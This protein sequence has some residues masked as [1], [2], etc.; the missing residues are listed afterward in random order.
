M[1]PRY[2]D[3]DKHP[4]RLNQS[5]PFDEAQFKGFLQDILGWSE[6]ALSRDNLPVHLHEATEEFSRLYTA[7][8]PT[9]HIWILKLKR[10]NPNIERS[11]LNFIAQKESEC[12]AV[13]RYP[14][15]KN[16]K[17]GLVTLI[18]GEAHYKW[19]ALAMNTPITLGHSC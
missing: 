19:M 13:I 17:L 2:D 16:W 14:E 8:H 15:V 9:L 6:F 18:D 1:R 3:P 11:L 5:T 10:Q 12:I 4:K 7:K